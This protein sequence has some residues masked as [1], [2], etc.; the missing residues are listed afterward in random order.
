MKYK[1]IIFDC[2]GVL[3][4][5]EGISNRILVEMANSVGAKI[6]L[7]YALENFAGK[8]LKSVFE[9]IEKLIEKKVPDS[10]E[11]EYRKK[12]FKAF[13]TELKPIRG[14]HNLLN[15]ISVQYCV[16]SSGPTKKIRLNLTTT[17]LIEKFENKI[18]SSYE[19]GSW[20]PNP[21]IFEYAA[22]KMGFKP[23]ECVVI[24]DSMAGIIAAR[25]GGFDVFGFTNEENKKDFEN[26][27]AKVFFEMGELNELLTEINY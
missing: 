10:F 5:S 21:E 2:D 18:F 25:K 27:G 19:I 4:D 7:K 11:K 6:E 3:V 17:K 24:E 20:K 12:T 15:E 26:E 23:N 16:A 14:I 8:S 22:E 13:K 1:C 9:H